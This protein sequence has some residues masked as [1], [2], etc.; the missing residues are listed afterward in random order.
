MVCGINGVSTTENSEKRTKHIANK[1]QLIEER[2]VTNHL[3]I[4]HKC[5]WIDGSDYMYSICSLPSIPP[6]WVLLPRRQGRV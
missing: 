4:I 2:Q 3:Q 6:S 1:K 5:H